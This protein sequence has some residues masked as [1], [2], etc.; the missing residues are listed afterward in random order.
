MRIVKVTIFA[1]IALLPIKVTLALALARLESAHVVNRSDSITITC[2][3]FGESVVPVCAHFAEVAAEILLAWATTVVRLTVV[4][5]STVE[6]ADARA[7]IR[8][9][10]VAVR[11]RLTVR[12]LEGWS[13]FAATRLLATVTGRIETITVAS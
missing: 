7:T 2:F 13:T 3:A 8:E 6:I 4:T 12:L 9:T 5:F 11:T 10:K 1:A